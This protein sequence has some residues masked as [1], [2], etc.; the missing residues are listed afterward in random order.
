LKEKIFQIVE[1]NPL[2]NFFFD[3]V[4]VGVGDGITPEDLQK[5]SEKVSKEKYLWIA[6]RSNFPQSAGD[7]KN[8]GNF[9]P[10]LT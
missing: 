10:N 9:L 6:C 1:E 8:F 5:V 7:L 2:D 3:E 4:P